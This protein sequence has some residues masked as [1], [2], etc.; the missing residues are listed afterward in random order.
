M[1][2]KRVFIELTYGCFVLRLNAATIEESELDAV[3]INHIRVASYAEVI[4][5][6]IQYENNMFSASRNITIKD[7]YEGFVSDGMLSAT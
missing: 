6:A 2:K 3:S 5:M 7:I 4:S 1:K